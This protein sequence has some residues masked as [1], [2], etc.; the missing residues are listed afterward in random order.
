M[1]QSE[2]QELWTQ[3]EADGEGTSS[4]LIFVR[5]QLSCSLARRLQHVL[6]VH[7]EVIGGRQKLEAHVD[8]DLHVRDVFLVLISVP[9]EQVLD[10]LF[11]DDSAVQTQSAMSIPHE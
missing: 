4:E 8:W 1:V 9:V 5:G 2:R 7:L 3:K 10:H 6:T 11:E